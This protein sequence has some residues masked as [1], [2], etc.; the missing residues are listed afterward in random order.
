LL[1]RKELAG[2]MNEITRFKKISPVAWQHINFLGRYEF[3]KPTIPI[4]IDK[5]VDNLS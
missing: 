5:I 4:D 3:Q 1:E 2:A